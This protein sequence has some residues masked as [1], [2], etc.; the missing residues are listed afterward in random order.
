MGYVFQEKPGDGREWRKE[1]SILIINYHDGPNYGRAYWELLK[2]F[3]ERTIEALKK[4]QNEG[5]DYVLFTHG[6]S[7]SR[8]G[9][10]TAR[11][12]VRKIMRGKEGTPYII[13]K[14]CI[15]YTSSFLA[16]VRK[17]GGNP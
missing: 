17:K 12:E 8:Q 13:R 14:G 4:A 5:I 16:V 1:T 10:Q 11:S 3:H 2:I 9:N 7:T 6:S 15:Q